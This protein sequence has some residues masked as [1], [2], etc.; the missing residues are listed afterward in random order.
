[1]SHEHT[2][3]Q[4]NQELEE[5]RQQ[6]LAM[7]GLVE[8]QIVDATRALIEN[9][10][11]LGKEVCDNDFKVNRLEV[12][13]DD[14]CTA[15]LA[16]R[17]P[18]AGDLRLV[19]AAIKTATDLEQIGNEAAK[20][21]RMA[22]ALAGQDQD[23]GQQSV[24]HDAGHL[25]RHVLEMIRAALDAFARVDAV[26]ALEVARAELVVDHEYEALIRQC[27]TLMM[28]DPRSIRQVMDIIWSVRALERIGDHA[29]N[30]AHYVIYIVTG[31]DLRHIAQEAV[32]RTVNG[33]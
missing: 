21:A 3:S 10:P 27:I 1:M 18:A 16:R 7:G 2:S 8:Q 4:F 20:V 24:L 32:D 31:K 29:R 14:E 12:V 15:I 5:V 17:Q 28:E 33:C 19:Y 25:S 30:I 26:A 22:A 11:L 13:I 9:E 6:V 23:Q